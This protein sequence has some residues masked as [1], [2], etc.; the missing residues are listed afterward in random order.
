MDYYPYFKTFLYAWWQTL[1]GQVT[2]KLH[3][4]KSSISSWSTS[5]H[6]N[7]HWETALAHLSIGHTYLTHSYH[8]SQ[9]DSPLCSLCRVPIS[10][11]H[12]LLSCPRYQQPILLLLFTYLPYTNLPTYQTSWW[13]PIHSALKI[14]SPSSDTYISFTWFNPLLFIPNLTQSLT[15]STSTSLYTPFQYHPTTVQLLTYNT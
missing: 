9:S 13:N 1:S 8:M 4:V 11:S 14:Y 15:P 2:N 12:F 6:K 7:R 3:T 10:V 5:F